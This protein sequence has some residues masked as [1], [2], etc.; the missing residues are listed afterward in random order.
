MKLIAA[1]G[2]SA[3]LLGAQSPRPLNSVTA[4]RHWS[5]SDVTRIAVE[6]SGEF[7][8]RTDRLHSPERI[9]F[10][11][12]N[13][14]PRI[15]SRRIYALTIE[16]KLVQKVRVAETNPGRIILKCRVQVGAGKEP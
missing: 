16:D 4:V 7:E 14:R 1:L 5:L 8:F 13:A 3:M 10:D 2:I 9:Y 11:I 6:V 12:L 15:E